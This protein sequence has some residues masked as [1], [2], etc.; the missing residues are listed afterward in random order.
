VDSLRYFWHR[1]TPEETARD[2]ARII[3]HY[4]RLW[5]I[6]KI[7]LIGYSFGADIMPIVY[8]RLPAHVQSSIIVI[9]LLAPSRAID[10]EIHLSEWCIETTPPHALPLPPEVKRIAP[11]KL[12]CIFGKEE[13]GTSLCTDEAMRDA[14]RIE[15]PGSHHFDRDYAVLADSIAA[16]IERARTPPQH[17]SP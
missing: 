3:T 10:F 1:R 16:K 12:Q 6:D 5:H 7:A 14:E 11:E 9:S 2:L 15:R 4:Q 13:E 17:T 8:N